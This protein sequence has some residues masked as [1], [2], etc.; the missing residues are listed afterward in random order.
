MVFQQFTSFIGSKQ[1][2][3]VK[4]GLVVVKNYLTKQIKTLSRNEPVVKLGLIVNS[5]L[6]RVS[7]TSGYSGVPQP[8]N[9]TSLPFTGTHFSTNWTNSEVEKIIK[10]R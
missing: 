5:I 10:P 1:L 4:E 9:Q 6:S 8:W 3:N 7:L 2:D